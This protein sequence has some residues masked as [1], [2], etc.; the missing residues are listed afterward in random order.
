MSKSVYRNIFPMSHNDVILG[1]KTAPV[2]ISVIA[3]LL[4]NSPDIR[5]L[6]GTFCTQ[7]GHVGPTQSQTIRSGW[8][9]WDKSRIISWYL[10]PSHPQMMIYKYH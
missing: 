4:Y 10:H 9:C 6:G 2:D 7:E 5:R 1:H 3:R 8:V